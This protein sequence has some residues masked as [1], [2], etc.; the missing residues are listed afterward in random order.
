MGRGWKRAEGNLATAPVLHPTEHGV[1][2]MDPVLA[3]LAYF[4]P[5]AE[6]P[7]CRPAAVGA[8]L[9]SSSAIHLSAPGPESK[10][11]GRNRYDPEPRRGHAA[12]S[13][14]SACADS[15]GHAP[16]EHQLTPRRSRAQ[17]AARVH[18]LGDPP[19]LISTLL[20]G[21]AHSPKAN[22]MLH[23]RACALRSFPPSSAGAPRILGCR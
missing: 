17:R 2:S 8:G 12:R 6:G 15:V 14:H 23:R 20:G 7:E 19:A 5:H 3:P 1:S 9:R 4:S 11:E 22:R 21:G 18:R 16:A 13:G 10:T